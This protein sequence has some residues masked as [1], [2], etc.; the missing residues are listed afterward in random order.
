[1]TFG[2]SCCGVFF[3][4]VHEVQAVWKPCLHYVGREWVRHVEWQGSWRSGAMEWVGNEIAVE[5]EKW[6]SGSESKCGK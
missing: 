1:L 2:K 3:E 6:K 5:S 4:V